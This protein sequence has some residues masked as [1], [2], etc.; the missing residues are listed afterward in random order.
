MENV[1][2]RAIA[3]LAGA[4]QSSQTGLRRIPPIGRYLVIDIIIF[5][6]LIHGL[7]SPVP[8]QRRASEHVDSTALERPAQGPDSPAA[9]PAQDS[10]ARGSFDR[11]PLLR[12]PLTLF[13]LTIIVPTLGLVVWKLVLASSGS[14]LAVNVIDFVLGAVLGLG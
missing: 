8:P 6:L 13:R 9:T 3:F 7:R 12:V 11:P 1:A 10:G 2:G 14:N 5:C 4:L